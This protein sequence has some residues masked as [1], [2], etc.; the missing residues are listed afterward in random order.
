MA[1]LSEA[2]RYHQPYVHV[3]DN[4][5]RVTVHQAPAD[6]KNGSWGCTV[7]DPAIVLAKYFE[8]C[9]SQHPGQFKGMRVL[10]LGAESGLVGLVLALLGA[11]PTISTQEEVK[12]KTLSRSASKLTAGTAE[13]CCLPYK[14]IAA[15]QDSKASLPYDLIVCTDQF[16]MYDL[17]LIHI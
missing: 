10:E 4:G 7:T 3:M 1:G 5:A 11:S 9:D 14:L 13:A 17:S 16:M 6:Y 8:H 2:E 15:D 12:L